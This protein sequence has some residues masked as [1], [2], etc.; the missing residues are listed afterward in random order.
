MH[1]SH[2]F[3]RDPETGEAYVLP[4]T[5]GASEEHV[6]GSL[7]KPDDGAGSVGEKGTETAPVR[8]ALEAAPPT[9]FSLQQIRNMRQPEKWKACEVYT[10]ELNGSLGEVHFPVAA[11]PNGPHPVTGE[12]GRYVDAPV[13]K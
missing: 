11:N 7:G 8:K 6:P 13:F 10:R 5:R 4:W 12:G 2:I 3:F 1:K 9:T